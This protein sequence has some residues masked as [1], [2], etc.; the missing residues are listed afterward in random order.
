LAEI[1]KKPKNKT[2]S[3][4]DVK[5]IYKQTSTFTIGYTKTIEIV[6]DVADFITNVWNL[7]FIKK[8]SS[9]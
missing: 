5:K 2:F 9:T 7:S 1:E 3:V 4:E 6:Y 8:S